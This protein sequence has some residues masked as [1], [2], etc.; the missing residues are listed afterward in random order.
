MD[1]SEE[2]VGREPQ[3]PET[4]HE[5]TPVSTET[6]DISAL[7]RRFRNIERE[8]GTAG[9][10]DQQ[11]MKTEAQAIVDQLKFPKKKLDTLVESLQKPD[12]VDAERTRV[13]AEARALMD[14]LMPVIP[15][16]ESLRLDAA[17]RGLKVKIYERL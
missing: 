3:T 10:E 14:Q 2:S 6:P 8:Y 5:E 16:P 17:I 9:V 11:R 1:S 12:L 15:F 7:V 4:L 13:Q